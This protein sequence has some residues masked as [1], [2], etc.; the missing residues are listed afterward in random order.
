MMKLPKDVVAI[1]DVDEYLERQDRND[2]T[3]LA[4]LMAAIMAMAY[5]CTC[6]VFPA[7]SG[8]DNISQQMNIL[9]AVFF[10]TAL[11]MGAVYFKNKEQE[12]SA[13]QIKQHIAIF[14]VS[15][16]LNELLQEVLRY[17]N[18]RLLYSQ[19]RRFQE[20]LESYLEARVA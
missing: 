14:A 16:A 7:Y 17:Q 13:A 11:V 4:C 3:T 2:L 15:P 10:I 9:I 18:G 19:L 1:A 8:T 5:Y 12:L 6:I 20:S